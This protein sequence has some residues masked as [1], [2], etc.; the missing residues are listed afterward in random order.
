[1][2]TTID[3][4]QQKHEDALKQKEVDASQLLEYI[5]YN[6]LT[7]NTKIE[8]ELSNVLTNENFALTEDVKKELT[9]VLQIS[10]GYTEYKV[11][12]IAE[13]SGFNRTRTKAL[14]QYLIQTNKIE[15]I[16]VANT[17]FIHCV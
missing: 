6:E 7:K 12:D 5:K 11:A 15:T 2:E 17:T 13:N 4:N 8:N 3:I 10:R 14:I 1:M 16:S 9:R